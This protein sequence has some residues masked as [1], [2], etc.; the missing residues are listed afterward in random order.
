MTLKYVESLSTFAFNFNL[1][2]YNGTMQERLLAQIEALERDKH[3]LGEV[4]REK[5]AAAQRSLRQFEDALGAKDLEVAGLRQNLED[6]AQQF[7]DM[8]KE[9]LDK[10]N[11]R[12][13]EGVQA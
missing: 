11:D 2:R 9:T 12:L 5:D 7:S 1:R 13:G 6:M 4:C 10:M 3:E 8:L